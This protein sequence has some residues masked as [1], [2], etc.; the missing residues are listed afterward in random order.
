MS[1]LFLE[2]FD[3]GFHSERW[4][5]VWD[6]TGASYGRHGDGA[7]LDNN[8]KARVNIPGGPYGGAVDADMYLGFAFKP[9][10]TLTGSDGTLGGF[11]DEATVGIVWMRPDSNGIQIYRGSST[12]HTTVTNVLTVDEWAYWELYVKINNTTGEITLKKNGSTVYT[13]T[14]DTYVASYYFNSVRFEGSAYHYGYYD[15]IYICS[16]SGT[17]NNTYLGDIRVDALVPSG[18]GNSSQL[19]G[20]DADSTDNYLHVDEVTQDGDTSY[21]EHATSGNKDT[22]AYDNLAVSPGTIHGISVATYAKKTDTAAKSFRRVLRSGGT[23]YTGSDVSLGTG[24]VFTEEIFET[25]PDTASAW[26]ESGVNAMEV[27]FEVRP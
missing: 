11:F 27:G 3:D 5:D 20:S 14:T 15:D 12:L 6:T 13:D 25:D 10:S 18:N 8:Q 21:V 26:T 19:T 24:Y 17:V 23:D 7:Y 2:G 9:T 16:S 22:Y 4:S 1:L